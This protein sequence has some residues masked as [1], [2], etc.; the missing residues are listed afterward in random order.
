MCE[1]I[2]GKN[3]DESPESHLEWLTRTG[4][5]KYKNELRICVLLEGHEHRAGLLFIEM[6]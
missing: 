6:S 5:V 2:A 1:V 4:H 3:N